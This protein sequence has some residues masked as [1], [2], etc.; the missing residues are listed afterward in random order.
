MSE[1]IF[2]FE[3]KV[4]DYECD[5]QGIVNNANYQHYYEVARH[6]FLEKLGVNFSN[7]HDVGTDLVVSSVYI[8][9]KHSLYGMDKF[10]CTIDRIERKG[11]RYIFHQKII[12]LSDMVV[13]SDAEVVVVCVINGKLSRPDEMDKIFKDYIS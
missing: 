7:L 10:L 5:A 1:S 13:C 8:K 4:R 11:V 2:S 3:I 6:E 12:R 9:Y